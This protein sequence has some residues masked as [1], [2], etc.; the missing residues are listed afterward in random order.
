MP[1]CAFALFVVAHVAAFF[2][3]I[4]RALGFA[5]ARD[6]LP[7]LNPA[8]AW[9]LHSAPLVMS[10]PRSGRRRLTPAFVLIALLEIGVV[11]AGVAWVASDAHAPGATADKLWC[12][13]PPSVV[14]V[15]SLGGR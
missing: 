7:P 9:Q 14:E 10:A 6:D 11:T 12:G 13:S 4:G 2:V 8:T 3:M 15:A 5:G 1:C